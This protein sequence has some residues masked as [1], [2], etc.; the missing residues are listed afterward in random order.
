MNVERTEV[1]GNDRSGAGPTA[2]TVVGPGPDEWSAA[3]EGP[4]G[5]RVAFVVALGVAA[6]GYLYL[7]REQ[8][9][10][11][12]EWA[13]LVRRD[14]ADFDSVINPH[15]EHLSTVPIMVMRSLFNVFGLRT[16]LPF[17]LVVLAAHLGVVA[18]LWKLVRRAGVPPWIATISTGVLL[19]YGPG[20]MNATVAVQ[21]G[22]TCGMLGALAFLYVADVDRASVARSIAAVACA[23]FG[24][25]S[26]GTGVIMVA[27]GLVVIVL[28]RGVLR[29]A[30][31]AA[32]IFLPYAWW[33]STRQ[34]DEMENEPASVGQIVR[35]TRTG[36]EAV[37]DTY[38]Y[39]SL[40]GLV[41]AGLAGIGLLLLARRSR[42]LQA[43]RDRLV[44]PLTYLAGAI[45][46]L[47][48]TSRGRVVQF[49]IDY[50]TR[51]RFLHTV[52]ALSIPALAVGLAEVTRRWRDVGVAACLV[53]VLAMPFNLRQ[54]VLFVQPG[55]SEGSLYLAATD[56]YVRSLPS[57]TRVYGDLTSIRWMTT[58][59]LARTY[60][61]GRFADDVTITP[62]DRAE[63]TARLL[64]DRQPAPVPAGC[65]ELEPD[66]RVPVGTDDGTLRTFGVIVYRVV[67]DGGSSRDVSVGTLETVTWQ[68]ANDGDPFQVELVD[69]PRSAFA[70]W[71]SSTPDPGA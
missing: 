41:I 53:L 46:F 14:G 47:V 2:D 32:P 68:P 26:S 15:N 38:A 51:P 58:G 62:S 31:L 30:M 19:F 7:A 64:I 57:N 1:G 54:T 27:I 13:Y 59:W 60:D 22:F 37:A 63:V 5:G 25:L 69:T 10:Y 44:F 33:W 55:V 66:D 11:L 48:V 20:A 52:L 17:Q 67:L 34:R 24:V 23:A 16:Y 9:F 28:R 42:T 29:A 21:I 12:D 71:C 70:V 6:V 36:V 8:W 61:Q 4:A 49:G 50:A 18:V 45:G 39:R 40:S 43:W 35:F 65:R 56:P 3:D